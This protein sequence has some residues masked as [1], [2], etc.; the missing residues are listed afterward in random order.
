MYDNVTLKAYNTQDFKMAASSHEVKLLHVAEVSG[1]KLKNTHYLKECFD[2]LREYFFAAINN[3]NCN[4]KSILSLKSGKS[5]DIIL[6]GET[7]EGKNITSKAARIA[8]LMCLTISSRAEYPFGSVVD[9]LSR[10]IKLR[11]ITKNYFNLV[12]SYDERSLYDTMYFQI[13]QIILTYER[14]L[15]KLI[16]KDETGSDYRYGYFSFEKSA[17]QKAKLIA[18][19]NA[20]TSNAVDAIQGCKTKDHLRALIRVGV[21][22]CNESLLLQVARK[23]YI[24]N[25]A[26][27]LDFVEHSYSDIFL[28]EFLQIVFEHCSIKGFQSLLDYGINLDK[29]ISVKKILNIIPWDSLRRYGNEEF[30]KIF[31]LILTW[32]FHNKPEMARLLIENPKRI[33]WPGDLQ[34]IKMIL[35]KYSK[36][37]VSRGM[38]NSRDYYGITL[39]EH[40]TEIIYRS[41]SVENQLEGISL[42][43]KLIF[44][45][46][47]PTALALSIAF[48][49]GAGIIAA[50]DHKILQLIFKCTA[51]KC[52]DFIGDIRE[53][54]VKLAIRCNDFWFIEQVHKYGLLTKADYKLFR[55]AIL[56]SIAT[57]Q[58]SVV[59]SLFN[60]LNLVNIFE[61]ISNSHELLLAAMNNDCEVI[62]IE[63]LLFDGA[64]KT[65]KS[66]SIVETSMPHV[67]KKHR[68]YID[69]LLEAAA[70]VNISIPWDELLWNSPKDPYFIPRAITMGCGMFS[71]PQGRQAQELPPPPNQLDDA[72]MCS[73]A[74]IYA[75]GGSA[76]MMKLPMDVELFSI[77]NDQ[78]LQFTSQN[79]PPVKSLK[80][81]CADIIFQHSFL[82]KSYKSD[83]PI[84]IRDEI[85][86]PCYLF[87]YA[88]SFLFHLYYSKGK[89]NQSTIESSI[90][91]L[92]N[93]PRQFL[94]SKL[95]LICDNT[96]SSSLGM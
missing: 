14:Y 26:V 51:I 94:P 23:G 12:T 45:G 11:T 83:I 86:I 18:L 1:G 71:S 63:T 15:N 64:L 85:E 46:V 44:N 81:S 10:L 89:I 49:L 40:I 13:D 21:T 52:N 50:L 47:M 74:L 75:A 65:S 24:D 41:S 59:T 56:D 95:N 6:D 32:C 30:R 3:G 60:I 2:D 20:I 82:F 29:I 53:D 77:F 19:E 87:D 34:N 4:A 42:L 80:R 5:I 79:P 35:A 39:F 54:R 88:L 31:S 58:L 38:L 48:K 8:D 76:Q 33:L 9:Y 28:F 69:L 62:F 70:H 22:I 17:D 16:F 43:E 92:Q 93:L 37:T 57:K 7:L 73:M 66:K 68:Q 36:D 61:Y 67:M 91:M 96:L 72:Q 90:M 27:I 55:Q 78:W 25:V 84:N